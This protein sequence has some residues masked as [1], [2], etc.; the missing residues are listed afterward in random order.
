MSHAAADEPV[1][2]PRPADPNHAAIRKLARSFEMAFAKGD[3][4]ACAAFWTENGEHEDASGAVT[5]GRANIEKTF[6]QFFKQNPGTK[7]DILLESIHFPAPGLA[8]E[9]GLMRQSGA[10]KRLPSTTLY[11]VT[12]YLGKEGWKIASAREWGAGQDR[13]QDLEWLV[14][15]WKAGLKGDETT[16]AF[17]WDGKKPFINGKFTRKSQGRVLTSGSMRIGMDPQRGQL[18]SWNFDDDGGFGQSLWLRDGNNWVLD[19]I[20]VTSDGAHHEAVNI[21]GRLSNNEL[22]WRSIDR[23]M[24]NEHLPDAAPVKLVRVQQGR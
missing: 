24:G 16:L 22:T 15:T 1:G 19:C 11:S 9:Q 10:G 2:H 20:G 5:R 23:V 8:V 4:R 3:A 6:A 21:L 13:L 7:I 17:T 18:R 14:G 12:H